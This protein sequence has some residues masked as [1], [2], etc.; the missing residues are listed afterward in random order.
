MV[1]NIGNY[2]TSL[3][4]ILHGKGW[5][6]K[7]NSHHALEEKSEKK[8]DEEREKKMKKQNLTY[9]PVHFISN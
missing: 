3:I 1:Q 8:T 9:S 2:F 5:K 7:E 6:F 4:Y